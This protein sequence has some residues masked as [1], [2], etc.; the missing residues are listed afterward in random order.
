MNYR[1]I[2]AKLLLYGAEGFHV[3]DG[4]L[5]IKD[6]KIAAVKCKS[7][8]NENL[9]GGRKE[10]VYEVIDAK[11]HL[12][13][14]G[15][16]NMHT[17]AYMTL[18]RNYADDIGFSEWLFEKIIPVED[19]LPDEAAYWTNLLGIAEMIKTGTTCYADMH[20]Y[21]RQSAKAASLAGIRAYIGRG[22]VGED[23]YMDGLS[24]FEAFKEEKEKYESELIKFAISPHAVYSC[25][26]KLY[27][28]AAE[29][30]KK[31]NILKQTHVSESIAEVNDCLKKHK[32]T[33]VQILDDAGF[34]DD[35]TILAHCV[36]MR[37]KDIETVAERGASAVTNAASNAKLGNGFAQ[38]TAMDEAGV[39][40][41]IGTDGAASNNTLN[42]FR[43]MGLLSLIHKGLEKD[44]VAMPAK[45]V[46]AAA[47]V[48]ASKALG[49]DGR[50]GIIRQGAEADLIFLNLKTTSL[51]PNNNIVSS[52]CYSANGSEVDSV[53][54]A[55][56]FV[57]KNRELTT[58]DLERVYFEVEKTAGKY[59]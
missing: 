47:T 38:L 52:L 11:D 19:T 35:K 21:K 20:P 50:L 58:I 27:R 53:M 12:V 39:N 31:M 44:P 7:E 30:A 15:L 33:P 6:G 18:F 26:E 28:Q 42:M 32:K 23:L 25:S 43:E 9:H 51:F 46:I 13:M 54:I 1:I 56:K 57:M 5:D 4:D 49:M 17:H 41:C 40:V 24:R 45:K 10:E 59:L 22:L 2:N 36:H 55:G 34:L 14:P 48:N 16:I 3:K 37:G 8:K 29:E